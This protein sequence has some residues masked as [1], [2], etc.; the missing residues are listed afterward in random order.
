MVPLVL[1]LAQNC[2]LPQA[3]LA[4]P[5]LDEAPAFNRLTGFLT[6]TGEPWGAVRENREKGHPLQGHPRPA[7][8]EPRSQAVKGLGDAE[9]PACPPSRV[10]QRAAE[11][12]LAASRH[13]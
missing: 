11:G 13:E 3:R 1:E 12:P 6:I 7:F 10:G 9:T 4:T 2:P 5:W 8:L